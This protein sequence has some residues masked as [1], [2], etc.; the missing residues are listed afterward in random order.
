MKP[1]EMGDE[2][3]FRKV[4]LLKLLTREPDETMKD[5]VASLANAGMF[6]LKEGEELKK[7][8]EEQGYIVNNELS[9]KGVM[10][11]K[12]AEQEFKL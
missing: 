12:K 4:F 5:V 1:E 10:E 2:E 8:L 9:V 7:K 11:A 3:L 6:T